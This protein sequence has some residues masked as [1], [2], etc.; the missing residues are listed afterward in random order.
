MP[1]HK[2]HLN[3][4]ILLYFF[5]A[6]MLFL[7]ASLFLLEVV[8]GDEYLRQAENARV[9]TLDYN[10]TR[11]RILDRFGR[12]LATNKYVYQITLNVSDVERSSINR[13]ILSALV[14]M[15]SLGVECRQKL[16]VSEVNWTYIFDC[17]EIDS[18]LAAFDIQKGASASEALYL[19]R[20]K[21]EIPEYFSDSDAARVIAAYIGTKKGDRAYTALR[22]EQFFRLMDISKLSGSFLEFD[23]S[24]KSAAFLPDFAG[25]DAESMLKLSK[26][27]DDMLGEAPYSGS[28]PITFCDSEPIYNTAE[29]KTLKAE[30]KAPAG[31]S[32]EQMVELLAKKYSAVD[33]PRDYLL[34]LLAARLAVTRQGYRMYDP[35]ILGES[36]DAKVLAEISEHQHTIP[37]IRVTQSTIRSY[38]YGEL[39]CQTLGYTGKITAGT[40]EYYKAKGY[41]ISRDIIGRDGLEN[42]LED[43]LRATS[44]SMTVSVDKLGRTISVLNQTPAGNGAD[45]VITVDLELQRA[46]EEAIDQTLAKMRNGEFG[47]DLPNAYVGA[48]AVVDIHTGEVLALASRPG[49][50]PNIFSYPVSAQTW[51]E[52]NPIYSLPDGT[53]SLDITLPRPM[54]NVAVMGS[55]PP[56]STFKLVTAAAALTEGVVTIAEEIRDLGKYTRFSEINPPACWTWNEV[57]ITHG[58]VN[59]VKAI[60]GSCNYYFFELGYRLGIEK[61]EQYAAMLGLGQKTGIEL[62]YDTAG[63]IGGKQALTAV[64]KA[65]TAKIIRNFVQDDSKHSA[66]QDVANEL[67]DKLVLSKAKTM[68]GELGLSQ[69]E[70]I[71]VYDYIDANRWRPS[72]VLAAAIGQGYNS[73]SALQMAQMTAA[74]AMGGQR[75]KP[76]LIYSV[77][78]LGKTLSPEPVSER[79]MDDEDVYAILEGM[80][81]VV[82]SGGTAWR[83]FRDCA[84]PI[85]GKTGTAQSE[86]RDAYAWFVALA[87]Y[88]NPRIAVAV[89]IG[90]GGSGAYAAPVARTIIEKYFSEGTGT[91]LALPGSLLN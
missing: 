55:A 71:Y 56:G 72:Q 58:L 39:L 17:A 32:A 4:I 68:L 33:V 19:L 36:E 75:F 23:S 81:G 88:E 5:V 27:L 70:I 40:E 51:A 63:A 28:L 54:V 47:K 41:N 42:T 74:V 20:Q 1:K 76:T 15:R 26:E 30:I 91:D 57:K 2:T 3:T 29:I 86:G 9:R 50:D 84:I 79:F 82:Q 10:G 53:Q 48:A 18:F 44:G 8:N 46:A 31:A 80:R 6:L 90:Q 25:L 83:Y 45:V 89:M 49:Y 7:A 52:I 38:P 65:Q 11:G 64:L 66:C 35:V 59:M 77:P 87:P 78:K 69:S 22:D 61:I 34:D 13:S 43:Y 24:R 16:P 85:I 21:F 60:Q 67:V 14:L 73:F 37:G 12:V 62:P